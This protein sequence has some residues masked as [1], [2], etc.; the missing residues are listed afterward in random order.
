MDRAN[1]TVIRPSV[2]S[3]PG[4]ITKEKIGEGGM[5]TVYLAIQESLDRTAALKI[6]APSMIAIDPQS[7]ERFLKE[8]RIVAHLTHPNIVTVYDIGKAQNCL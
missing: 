6:V 7:S 4:Y 3:I 8:G 1:V 5:A 2:P